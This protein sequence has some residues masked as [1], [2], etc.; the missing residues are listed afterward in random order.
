MIIISFSMKLGLSSRPANQ[1]SSTNIPGSLRTTKRKNRNH[2]SCK[3]LHA[4]AHSVRLKPQV[5]RI[6]FSTCGGVGC[7][8][9]Y[10]HPDFNSETIGPLRYM[11]SLVKKE[12]E[13]TLKR[14]NVI[15]AF[16]A[17]KLT[18][19]QQFETAIKRLQRTK[20]IIWAPYK[21]LSGPPLTQYGAF[22]ARSLVKKKSGG[23]LISS[24]AR[25]FFSSLSKGHDHA[26]I[27]K[28]TDA[29]VSDSAVP[30][31]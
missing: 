14:V 17:G 24:P 10:C 13:D 15:T 11:Q 21:S 19:Q 5:F 8:L 3:E 29:S 18:K 27:W 9:D 2:L 1:T 28:R 23:S 22:V 25:H 30:I 4:K 16:Q 7:D 26:Y 20:Q 31:C 12:G 6:G